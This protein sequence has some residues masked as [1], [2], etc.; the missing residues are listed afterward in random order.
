KVP[1]LTKMFLTANSLNEKHAGIAAFGSFK[2]GTMSLSPS[3]S[4]KFSDFLVKSSENEAQF[5]YR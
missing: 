2:T 5:S 4:Q 1:P 3:C